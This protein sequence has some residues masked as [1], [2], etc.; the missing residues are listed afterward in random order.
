MSRILKILIVGVTLM[1]FWAVTAPRLAKRLVVERK[2]KKADVIFVLS[3]SAVYPE[4]TRKAASEYRAGVSDKVLLSDD[5]QLAGWSV[6]EQRNP[7]FVELSRRSLERYGVA[8]ES[9]EVMKSRVSGTI[10]E[11]VGFRGMAKKRGWNSVLVVTSAY[12]TRRAFATFEQSLAGTGIKVG[13]TAPVPGEFM[14]PA[15]T[16]WLTSKGCRY[17]GGEYLKS[18]YYWLFY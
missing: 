9:I 16:W 8:D 2:L 4:R 12:H 17:V 10:D 3:G 11:A 18:L 6:T 14:P 13:V 7:R 1:I 5:G 15:N